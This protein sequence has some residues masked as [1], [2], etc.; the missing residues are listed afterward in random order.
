M[1]KKGF[2]EEEVNIRELNLELKRT[3][4]LLDKHISQCEKNH[5]DYEKRIVDLEKTSSYFNIWD[6][7][8][9]VALV[10]ASGVI[11]YLFQLPK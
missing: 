4:D 10:I 9:T 2:S 6:K 7:L 5:E 1:G 3:V 11:G 8:K